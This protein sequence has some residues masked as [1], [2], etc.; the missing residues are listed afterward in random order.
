MRL[1][2]CACRL[3][4]QSLALVIPARFLPTVA[5]VPRRPQFEMALMAVG[6]SVL[7]GGRWPV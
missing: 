6:A 7:G 3:A 1:A 4:R 2:R 5:A